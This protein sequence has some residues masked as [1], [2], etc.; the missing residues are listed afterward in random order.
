MAAWQQ[1]THVFFYVIKLLTGSDKIRLAIEIYL[2]S[3]KMSIINQSENCQN[4]GIGALGCRW[5]PERGATGYDRGNGGVVGTGAASGG[6]RCTDGLQLHS[7][8]SPLLA[9]LSSSALQCTHNA[10]EVDQ[11]LLLWD[12]CTYSKSEEKEPSGLTKGSF[13][14]LESCFLGAR[15]SS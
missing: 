2:K 9:V 14:S 5:V 15:N 3:P 7:L 13:F 11:A 8:P 12:Y 10:I 6:T 4:G 1:I